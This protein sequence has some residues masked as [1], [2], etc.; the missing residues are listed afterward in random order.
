MCN[1]IQF[2]NKVLFN[3]IKRNV[4]KVKVTLASDYILIKNSYFREHFLSLKK[5]K[6]C[7]VVNFSKDHLN[8]FF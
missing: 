2:S 4:Q 3:Y 5:S 6:L 1:L 7:S 8:Y